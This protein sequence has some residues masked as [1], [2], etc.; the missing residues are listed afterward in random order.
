MANPK[1]DPV[2]PEFDDL[3]KGRLEA[4]LPKR[5]RVGNNPQPADPVNIRGSTQSK[6]GPGAV[7]TALLAIRTGARAGLAA[8]TSVDSLKISFGAAELRSGDNAPP[9]GP[10][11]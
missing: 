9:D 3:I 8:K 10:M 4:N 7:E 5:V 2:E 1:L 11:G 6:D